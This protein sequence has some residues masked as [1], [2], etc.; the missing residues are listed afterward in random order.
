M[1]LPM[2]EFETVAL[3]TARINDIQEIPDRLSPA[4][5]AIIAAQREE[6]QDLYESL[7]RALR[8]RTADVFGFTLWATERMQVVHQLRLV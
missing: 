4:L 7:A 8:K 2:T 5:V 1:Q 3:W 6:P